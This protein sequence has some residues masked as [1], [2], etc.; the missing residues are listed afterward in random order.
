MHL[1]SRY[2]Y[3]FRVI[4]RF[5]LFKT[6]TKPHHPYFWCP[7]E[8]MTYFTS[9]Q[10][11]K[12]LENGFERNGIQKFDR[13]WISRMKWHKDFSQKYYNKYL[14][15]IPRNYN[16]RT[17]NTYPWHIKSVEHYQYRN[18]CCIYKWLFFIPLHSI[19]NWFA[20]FKYIK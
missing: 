13:S 3:T 20:F 6:R 16:G 12:E 18:F 9:Y 4:H 2:Q 1:L 14:L 17:K 10:R 11:R 5:S 7:V 19:S 8:K 15:H